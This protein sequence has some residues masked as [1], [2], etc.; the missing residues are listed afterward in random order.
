MAGWLWG[1]S[2]G[3]DQA[4]AQAGG[5]SAEF[6]EIGQQIEL[7]DVLFG[8]L[9]STCKKKCISIEYKEADLTRG[10]AVCIDRCAEKYFS[11]VER[12]SA[13]L[14]GGG[15]APASGSALPK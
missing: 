7:M 9:V 2:A 4:Q 6:R 8:N 14:A 13:A 3:R 11:A 12:V 1:G 10:E 15:A 5:G